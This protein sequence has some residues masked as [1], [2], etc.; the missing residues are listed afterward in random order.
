[1]LS[2]LALGVA[3]ILAGNGNRAFAIA[4]IVIGFG[5][6]GI[7]MWLWRQHNRQGQ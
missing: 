5:W 4:W 2:L 3:I 6:F 7:S 1:M